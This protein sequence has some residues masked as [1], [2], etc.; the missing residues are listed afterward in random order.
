MH[1]LY[2]IHSEIN[3]LN[4]PVHFKKMQGAIV[5]TFKIFFAAT[6]GKTG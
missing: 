1:T 3:M 6:S 5:T 2:I 4:Y